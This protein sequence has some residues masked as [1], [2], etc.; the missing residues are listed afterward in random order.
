MHVQIAYVCN[1]LR[2]NKSI[3]RPCYGIDPSIFSASPQSTPTVYA[4]EQVT[5]TNSS[6]FPF[7]KDCL[8]SMSAS[9]MENFVDS[10][11]LSLVR[12]CCD[13]VSTNCVGHN[14]VYDVIRVAGSPSR[15]VD[16]SMLFHRE[17]RH[18]YFCV[19]S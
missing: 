14:L 4:C 7:I 13:S 8:P 17:V 16:I 12:R 11:T 6:Q 5:P 1:I 2:E 15:K 19:L 9:S 10:I 18:T 3:L